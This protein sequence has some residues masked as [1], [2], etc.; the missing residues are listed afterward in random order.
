LPGDFL[1]LHIVFK[2]A[3]GG[4]FTEK[5]EFIT[6]PSLLS[7]ASLVLT[8]RGVA[9]Q[10]DKHKK[11]RLAIERKLLNKEAE[12]IA[13]QMLDIVLSGVRT[14]ER[15]QSPLNSYLTDEDI[16]NQQNP[17]VHILAL[18]EKNPLVL[19]LKINLSPKS[20]ENLV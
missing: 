11:N 14:P 20:H 5:W 9:I 17:E 1:K 19:K 16:F 4:I 10:E 15:C 13:R 8:L 18:L 3:R 6:N 2:S 7:S 12:L